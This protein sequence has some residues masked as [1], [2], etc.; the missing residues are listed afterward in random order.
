VAVLWLGLCVDFNRLVLS[1]RP[2][3]SGLTPL[4]EQRR[5]FVIVNGDE[6]IVTVGAFVPFIAEGP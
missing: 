4:K 5:L 1:F 2:E 6:I 3:F